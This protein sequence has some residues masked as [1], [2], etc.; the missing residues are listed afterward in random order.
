MVLKQRINW[1]DWAKVF[2]IYLVVLGHLLSKTGREGYIFNFIYSFH[3]PFF[4]FISGYLFTIKEN[5]F[6]S[7]LKGS[8]RSLLVPYVLLNLIGNFFLIPTWVLAKQWPID[9]LFYFITAD[10]RGEPGPTWFLVCLFQV[11]L[12]SYFIVRQ[13]SVWRLLVVLF[14][15]LIAYLFPFHLYWRIDTVFMV[16]PFYIAGYELKSKLSFFSSKISFFILLLIVLLLTMIMGYSNVYLRLFGNY[17][18]LYYPY[19][20][21]GIFMLI[22]LSFMF[23]KYNFK[24]ITILSIGTI[25]IMALHGII[26]L[27]V[28]TFFRIVH[29]D[30]IFLTTTGKFILSGIVLLLLYYPIIWLHKYFP[31]AIGRR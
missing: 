22:S 27:Y 17:P 13:T 9:Q 5:N 14:C 25:V 8:I 26:F 15:I 10:G 7:F 31:M 18:L 24:F 3:M 2:A 29:L 12:L 28:K 11:R 30:F 6:R 19:A 16:I 4:F 1:I 20:F 23:D 21:A